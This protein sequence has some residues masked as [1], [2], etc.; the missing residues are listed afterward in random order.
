MIV[1]QV[2]VEQL[3][4]NVWVIILLTRF[5]IKSTQNEA[6]AAAIATAEQKQWRTILFN[7]KIIII[8][9]NTIWLDEIDLASKM[10]AEEK[11]SHIMKNYWP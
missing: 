10:N 2:W 6:A 1:I 4:Y 3:E 11:C 8:I 5:E 7:T 9:I